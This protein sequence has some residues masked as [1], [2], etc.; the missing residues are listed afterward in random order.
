MK[1]KLNDYINNDYQFDFF[2]KVGIVCLVIV[3]SGI[4]GWLYE[5]IFYFFNSGMKRFYYRGGN[6][7]PFINIYAYGAMIILFLTYK[8]RKKPLQVFLISMLSCG[9]L[10]LVTGW[11]V[12]R[13]NN[14]VRWW[15]YNE[16]ILNFGNIGGYVCLRSVLFFGLS[17]LLLIYIILPW[18]FSLTHKLNK[19]VF[20]I[21][22]I[23]L[24]SI[25]IIDELYN[26]IFARVLFL[27]RATDIYKKLGFNFQYFMK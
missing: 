9:L 7:L 19:K 16:E 23:S 17:G 14:G 20:L 21:I 3:V 8:K 6:F 25:F 5:F 22:S 18:I 26:L 11:F 1:K 27:P 10:E 2:T 12:P 4:F 24:C 13:L 15:S